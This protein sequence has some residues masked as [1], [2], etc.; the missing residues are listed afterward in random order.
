MRARSAA[1]L[2]FCGLMGLDTSASADEQAQFDFANGLFSRGFNGEAV[3]EYRNYLAQYPQ[4]AHRPEAFYRLGESEFA[5]GHFA[6]AIEVFDQLLAA[7]PTHALALTVQ[8]R[9]GAAL[10]QLGKFDDAVTALGPATRAEAAPEVR[11]GALYY[12]GKSHFDAKRIDQ[13]VAA[14]RTLIETLPDSAYT[15]PARY[16]LAFVHLAQSNLEQAAVTFS[17]LASSAGASEELRRE[18]LFR[19]AEAY[20]KLGWHDAAVRAYEQLQN[21]FPN[22]EHADRAVLGHAWAL[23]HAARYD[24]AVAVARKQLRAKPAA[25]L[26]PGLRYLVGNCLQQTGKNAEALAEFQEVQK[27]FKNSEYAARAQ[28]KEGHLRYTAGESE[29]AH[30]VLEAFLARKLDTGLE[31][32]A[33]HLLGMIAYAASQLEPALLY[34]QQS[35]DTQPP[36][37]YR[38]DSAWQAAQTLYDLGRF[39]D[40]RDRF[41]AFSTEFAQDVRLALALMRAGDAAFQLKDFPA[42]EALYAQA[43]EKAPADSRGEAIYRLAAARHNAGHDL[44]AAKAYEQ[45]IAEFPVGPHTAEAHLRTG[46]YWLATGA[47]PMKAIS[48]FE[49]ALKAEPEGG[50][51]G[52][53]TKGLALAR[54]EAKDLDGAA[55]GFANLIRKWPAVTLNEST[56]AWAG[57][58]LFDKQAWP[59]AAVALQALLEHV[60]GYPDRPRVALKIAECAERAGQLDDALAKYDAVAAAAPD[61]PAS[62]EARFRQAAIQEKKNNPDRAVELY[63][64]AADSAANGD[65]GARARF[66]LGE[67]RFAQGQFQEAAK[68][69]MR[70]AIL[71]LHPQLAPEALFRAGECFE[72]G[73]ERDQAVKTY[74]EVV[75]EYPD[76]EQAAK[77]KQRLAELA[78]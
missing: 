8:G 68:H 11:G 28:Y 18:A 47:E 73:G 43:I 72:K 4:G 75:K 50:L 42:A 40:S 54:Y 63:L 52:E 37:A 44:D 23:Y 76:T 16:Q 29:A 1:L 69:Y 60:P 61:S 67:L 56:Y 45:L 41:V 33:R 66:R 74:Q 20:D 64:Q 36:G 65:I 12:L 57:Q 21:E 32:D 2:I 5:L 62:A 24:D 3:A 10:Y 48:H 58:Y 6:P 27:S 9:K 78:A 59:D 55:Q 49:V 34:F 26:A 31:A 17:E 7:F 25:A 70:V 38:A 35:L 39:T 71:Y 51:G 30:A 15:P 53:L 46:Q 22:S 77:A 14:F 19:A 13:A